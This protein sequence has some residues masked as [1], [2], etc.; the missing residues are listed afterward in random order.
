MS[1]PRLSEQDAAAAC[2]DKGEVVALL[3]YSS[4]PAIQRRQTE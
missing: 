3:V 1:S 2:E 4:M